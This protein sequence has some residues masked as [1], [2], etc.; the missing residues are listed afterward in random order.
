M[1]TNIQ[2]EKEISKKFFCGKEY[3]ITDLVPKL[4]KEEKQKIKSDI[5]SKL[6][7]VFKKYV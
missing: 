5:E 2:Y 4:K 6:F 3:V 1:I 7:D